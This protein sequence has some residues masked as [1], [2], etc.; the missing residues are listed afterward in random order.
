M[1][2]VLSLPNTL[3]GNDDEGL[4]LLVYGKGGDE[5]QTRL[6]RKEKGSILTSN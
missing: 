1:K 3:L 6:K 2:K 5:A 4:S